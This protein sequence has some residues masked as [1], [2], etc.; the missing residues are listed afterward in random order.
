VAEADGRKR[1]FWRRD[2]TKGSQLQVTDCIYIQSILTKMVTNPP[3]PEC[4]ASSSPDRVAFVNPLKQF[5]TFCFQFIYLQEKH[6][7]H[8]Q[9]VT[10][11][12]LIL[13]LPLYI[14]SKTVN[15]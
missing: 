10:S 11:T 12:H 9:R 3:P 5:L 4:L 13:I 15:F 2:Q 7:H 6:H 1:A 14:T 8:S